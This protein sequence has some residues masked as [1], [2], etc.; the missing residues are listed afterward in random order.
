MRY[1]FHTELFCHLGYFQK[2]VED[3]CRR[4]NL[5]IHGPAKLVTLQLWNTFVFC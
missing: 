5:F 3:L 2:S 1:F 4:E